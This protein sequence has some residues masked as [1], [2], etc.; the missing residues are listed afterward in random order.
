MSTGTLKIGLCHSF[1]LFISRQLERKVI[2]DTRL[3]QWTAQLSCL[4]QIGTG[5][6]VRLQHSSSIFGHHGPVVIAQR[7]LKLYHAFVKLEHLAGV[8]FNTRLSWPSRAIKSRQVMHRLPMIFSDGFFVKPDDGS[9]VFD[10]SYFLQC[11]CL[12]KPAFSFRIQRRDVVFFI[13]TGK[14][15]I[16]HSRSS[17]QQEGKSEDTKRDGFS[18]WLWHKASPHPKNVSSGRLT[19]H[20]YF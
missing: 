4:E 10:P 19:V 12:L 17:A 9:P 2:A 18:Q 20:F 13:C 6:S 8:L 16:G 15:W 1:I 14:S 3:S 5:H 7:N 11:A